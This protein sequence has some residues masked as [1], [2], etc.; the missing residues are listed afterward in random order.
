V[1]A[2]LLITG[3]E[4]TRTADYQICLDMQALAA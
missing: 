2:P 3:F 4:S 1:R